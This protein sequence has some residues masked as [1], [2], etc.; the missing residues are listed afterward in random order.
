MFIILHNPLSKNR[1]SKR[2]TKKVI[3]HF[4]EK[5]VPFRL[6]SLLKIKDIEHYIK[7]K[8]E[9]I[10]ILLLG[11]DGTINTFINKTY[12]LHI[13]QDIYV[14][15]N[16]SGND[17]LRSLKKQKPEK[18]R[19]N[20]LD[21]GS[22]HRFFMNGAGMGI[23]GLIA[24]KVNRSKNKRRMNYFLNTL[25]AFWSYSPTYMEVKVDGTL[26][27]FKKAYLV[28]I[29][30]GEYIG[31]GMRL[32]PDARLSDKQFNVVVVHGM[33]KLLLFLIFL[34]VYF[35]IHKKFKR[36][37]FMRKA[38]HVQAAMFTRQYAQ[39]DGE[40]FPKTKQIEA[41]ATDK[42]ASFKVFDW[43]TLDALAKH[44]KNT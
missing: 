35:G 34:S 32:A 6:K 29:N 36:F 26:H 9:D 21:Y 12:S 4:K 40:T 41:K 25:K 15:G 18:Q 17:F 31:G 8:P 1:K 19:V 5:R 20:R 24:H 3:D 16:G 37:V 43:D 27:T 23:D 28:N 38:N 42:S 7:H 44:L 30:S 13:T 22:R 39:C 33:S 11:G 2:T 10:K 14:M